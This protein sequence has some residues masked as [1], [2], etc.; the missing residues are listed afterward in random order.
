V[1]ATRR[2]FLQGAA[3]SLAGNVDYMIDVDGE[4]SE[5]PK[6]EQA[7]YIAKSAEKRSDLYEN[8][9]YIFTVE[10]E[11]LDLLE[12]SVKPSLIDFIPGTVGDAL[13]LVNTVEWFGNAWDLQE[14]AEIAQEGIRNP[15]RQEGTGAYT[16]FENA[17]EELQRLS[18]QASNVK[19]RAEDYS[20]GDD[21]NSI[22]QALENEKAQ[23]G[24]ADSLQKWTTI[25]PDEYAEPGE[26]NTE[27]RKL[28]NGAEAAFQAL[29]G[30]EDIID[31]Q[32]SHLEDGE[33]MDM[34][35]IVAGVNRNSLDN[36]GWGW[37]NPWSGDNFNLVVENEE[38]QELYRRWFKTNDSYEIEDYMLEGDDAAAN[39]YIEESD[40][41]S[42]LQEGASRQKLREMHEEGKIRVEGNGLS[43]IEYDAAILGGKGLKALGDGIEW[44]DDTIDDSVKFFRNLF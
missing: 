5:S 15:L 33:Y 40:L 32:V 7:R 4:L 34:P 43:M 10:E 29:T 26:T 14:R 24:R 25:D 3:G 44:V 42:L 35:K 39:I 6:K 36:E 27:A 28:K 20:V 12:E 9:S 31:N 16:E 8:L 13:N 1:E 21:W 19:E 22:H 2:E 38:E 11:A 18:D 41:N 37:A 23:I 30:F 17:Y